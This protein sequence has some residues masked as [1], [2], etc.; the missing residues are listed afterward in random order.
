MPD[1]EKGLFMWSENQGG[2]EFTPE[3][4]YNLANPL[5]LNGYETLLLKGRFAYIKIDHTYVYETKTTPDT[6]IRV[7]STFRAISYPTCC[8]ENR[9]IYLPTP[10][11]G[12]A[13]LTID[14]V[15]ETFRKGRLLNTNHWNDLCR[16]DPIVWS[17]SSSMANKYEHV[18]RPDED[19]GLVDKPYIY[20]AVENPLVLDYYPLEDNTMGTLYLT[21]NGVKHEVH[22]NEYEIIEEGNIQLTEQKSIKILAQPV[23][24]MDEYKDVRVKP[25]MFDLPRVDQPN[26][27]DSIMPISV[28]LERFTKYEN[29][30]T[31]VDAYFTRGRIR[32]DAKPLLKDL[33]PQQYIRTR[34][35]SGKYCLMSGHIITRPEETH[36]KALDTLYHEFLEFSELTT[37]RKIIFMKIPH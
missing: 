4:Q 23:V 28:K 17:A 22:A 27:G 11:V 20:Q 7:H 33:S 26:V 32:I 15:I 8:E 5:P 18:L 36:E 6:T 25:G 1:L 14:L 16:C 3:D 10:T 31:T 34:L 21:I 2:F 29:T 30:L 9:S 19:M 35:V 12:D 24:V 37:V 13:H